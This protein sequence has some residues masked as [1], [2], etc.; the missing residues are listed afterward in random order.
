MSAPS[1]S[2]PQG[3]VSVSKEEFFALL[4]MDPRDIMPNHDAN[5]EFTVWETPHREV[6]GRSVPGWRNPGAPQEYA[7]VA[8]ALRG[9]EQ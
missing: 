9:D 6:W 4:R 8:A 3:M 1:Q 2:V 7:V 5:P